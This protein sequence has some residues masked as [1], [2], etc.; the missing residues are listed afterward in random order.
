MN[1]YFLK[2]QEIN[3]EKFGISCRADA[4]GSTDFGYDDTDTL[5]SLR[6]LTTLPCSATYVQISKVFESK[7]VAI[8]LPISL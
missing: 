7:I 1:P 2:Y 8:F 6:H 3:H 4:V 5:E